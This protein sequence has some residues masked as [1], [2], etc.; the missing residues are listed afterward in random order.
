MD[1]NG[2]V[3]V[4]AQGH[5]SKVPTEL[6]L[7]RSSASGENLRFT[8]NRNYLVRAIKLGFRELHLYGTGNPV[9]AQ[10]V[11]RAY[12]WAPLGEDGVI[13]PRPQGHAN[14]FRRWLRRTVRV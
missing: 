14:R 9:Q 11:N 12:V 5:D 7:S 10:H 4:R 1:L 3:I 6:L 13:K 2:Q 8:T